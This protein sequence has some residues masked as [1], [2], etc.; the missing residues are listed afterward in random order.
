MT[1]VERSDY[2]ERSLAVLSGAAA[3]ATL[4]LQPYRSRDLQ[5]LLAMLEHELFPLDPSAR[6][7]LTSGLDPRELRL[8]VRWL[9][10]CVTL[11]PLPHGPLGWLVDWAISVARREPRPPAPP[12]PRAPFYPFAN[13]DAFLRHARLHAAELACRLEVAGLPTLRAL[14]SVE[15]MLD[16]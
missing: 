4:L 5:W 9:L 11:E 16:P 12:S 3:P 2:L 7:E 8:H 10:W 14:C 1:S 13:R 15:G 6:R